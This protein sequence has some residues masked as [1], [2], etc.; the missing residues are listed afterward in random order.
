MKWSQWYK[1]GKTWRIVC[2]IVA[3]VLLLGVIA[4]G[5]VQYYLGK[6][7]RYSAEDDY[8]MSE[9]QIRQ[10]EEEVLREEWEASIAA[11]IEAEK[12]TTSV[13]TAPPETTTE[14][15]E[16]PTDAPTAPP[17]QTDPVEETHYEVVNILLIGQDR[18]NTYERAQSDTMILCSIDKSDN[19]ITLTSFLRD[20]YVLIPGHNDGRLNSVYPIGGM[21]L[22]N[23]TLKDNFGVE[24]DANIEVDFTGFQQIIDAMGGVDIEV[25]KEEA[26]HLEEFYDDI[27]LVP[28]MNHMNGEAALAYSR[29]RYI[30]SDFQRTGRQRAVLNALIDRVRDANML[31]VLSLIDTVLPLIKTDMTDQQILSYAMEF[32]P[33]LSGC[34]IVSQRVPLDG[35]YEYVYVREI[36]MIKAFP[37]MTRD[38]LESTTK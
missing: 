32:F 3:V 22:L 2:V 1:N 8:T 23:E 10:M 7:D 16:P 14:P 4:A 9:E 25:T 27:H 26:D 20:L 24:V 17:E 29:I 5:L 11:S 35:G 18:R 6:I 34:Q 38:L 12:Q 37:N 33:M 21:K 19:T 36:S 30:D 15:T 28:G 13:T 31:Q